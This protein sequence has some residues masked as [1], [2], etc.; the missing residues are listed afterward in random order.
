MRRNPSP[1]VEWRP[2]Q[3]DCNGIDHRVLHL[4]CSSAKCG[5]VTSIF[6]K[7]D[8]NEKN[9]YMHT[10]VKRGWHVQMS[11]FPKLYVCIC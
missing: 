3:V 6:L 1:V 7:N 9:V 11:T 8:N 5:P 2:L 4:T 10:N